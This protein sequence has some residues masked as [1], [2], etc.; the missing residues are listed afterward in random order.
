MSGRGISIVFTGLQARVQEAGFHACKYPYPPMTLAHRYTP[1]PSC[2]M[3]VHPRLTL[4][5]PRHVCTWAHHT[6]ITHI[7]RGNVANSFQWFG[8]IRF[9]SIRL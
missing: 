2:T 1:T 8:V 4:M 9:G 7:T 5:H 3:H 6:H